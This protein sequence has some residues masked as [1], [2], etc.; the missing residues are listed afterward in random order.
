[1][2]DERFLTTTPATR[3]EISGPAWCAGHVWQD[4]RGLWWLHQIGHR[5]RLLRNQPPPPL[6]RGYAGG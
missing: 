5:L 1:M 4:K 6:P 2:A 3:I